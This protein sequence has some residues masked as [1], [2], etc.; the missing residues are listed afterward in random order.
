MTPRACAFLIAGT[1]AFESL[2]VSR[3]VFAPPAIMFSMAVTWPALSPSVLPEA[4]SSRAPLAAAA[5]CAPSFIF[6]KNGF[7]SV[8]VMSPITGA[9]AA[10]AGPAASPARAARTAR[11]TGRKRKGDGHDGRLRGSVERVARRGRP[12]P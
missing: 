10:A 4:L 6:T 9:S 3:I 2:G 5:A 7:V 1:I 8:L 12:E 11:A